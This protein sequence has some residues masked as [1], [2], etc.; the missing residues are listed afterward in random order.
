M[1]KLVLSFAVVVNSL[2]YSQVRV[3]VTNNL[4]KVC[5]TL[6]HENRWAMCYVITFKKIK[7]TR[8]NVVVYPI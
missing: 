3:N 1:K 8:F 6:F 2:T 4:D 5:F 7:I